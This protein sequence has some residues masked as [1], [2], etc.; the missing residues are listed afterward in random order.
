[1]F[2]NNTASHDGGAFAYQSNP[3]R[4]DN[5]TVF[6]RNQARYGVNVASY[7]KEVKIQFVSS[8]DYLFN[9]TVSK[10]NLYS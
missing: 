5:T 9:A 3:V 8:S 10:R 6:L 4:Y 1:M 2:V 7:P